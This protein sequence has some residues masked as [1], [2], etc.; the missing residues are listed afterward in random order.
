[1]HAATS[2]GLAGVGGVYL[3]N[4]RVVGAHPPPRG[5][6]RRLALGAQC[7]SRAAARVTPA[8][9]FRVNFF[10]LEVQLNGSMVSVGCSEPVYDCL[11]AHALLPEYHLEL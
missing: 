10:D 4:C 8:A 1:M 6:R 9:E 11:A 5:R 7:G 2:A 3:D